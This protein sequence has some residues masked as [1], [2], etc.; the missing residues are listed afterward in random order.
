MATYV[1]DREKRNKKLVAVTGRDARPLR[2][3]LPTECLFRWGL[4][5]H[6]IPQA[7]HSALQASLAAHQRSPVTFFIRRTLS[8]TRKGIRS[9]FI[10][11]FCCCTDPDVHRFIDLFDCLVTESVDVSMRKLMRVISIFLELFTWQRSQFYVVECLRWD[12][13]QMCQ[14]NCLQFVQTGHVTSRYLVGST[15][16]GF[17]HLQY[18]SRDQ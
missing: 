6:R 10:K 7:A 5:P 3:Q 1:K 9:Q 17:Y 2:G 14:L 8:V 15:N 13:W 18:G 12:M 16:S 11:L 4:R